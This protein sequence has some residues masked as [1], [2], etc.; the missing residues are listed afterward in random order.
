MFKSI[1]RWIDFAR[2]EIGHWPTTKG[3]GMDQRTEI[4]TRLLA[5]DESPLD[6]QP[7]LQ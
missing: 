2:D 5:H 1:E 7:P 3:L 4:L 6:T